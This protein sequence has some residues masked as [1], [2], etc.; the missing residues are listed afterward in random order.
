MPRNCAE[1]PPTF[2]GGFEFFVE[3]G[4]VIKG[5]VQGC[6]SILTPGPMVEDNEIFLDVK[7]LWH[8][9][10]RAVAPTKARMLSASLPASNDALPTRAW[11]IPVSARNSHSPPLEDSTAFD[12]HGDGSQFRVWHQTTWARILHRFWQSKASLSGVAIQ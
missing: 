2:I 8:R 6:K 4:P 10:V 12:V 3:Q 7:C 9:L 5:S 1:K 11:T